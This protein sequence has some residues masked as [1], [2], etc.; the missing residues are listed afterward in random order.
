MNSK[1]KYWLSALLIIVIASA[2]FVQITKNKSWTLA[3]Y[4]SQKLNWNECYNNFE[5]AT[6]EVPVDYEKIDNQNFKLKVLRH[7]ASDNKNRIGALVVNPGG[8]GGSATDYAFNALSIVSPDIYQRYDIVGFDPRGV[9][10]SEPIRCLSNSEEDK[11]LDVSA[12]SGKPEE[13]TN[14]VEVSK[15]FAEK[16]AK[17]A[18][19]R[20]GHYSTLETAKDLE[21]LRQVLRE[22]KLN[23]LGKSYGTYLGT[24]YASLYPD[25][26]GKFVLDGAVAPNISLR[27]QEEAQ[28]LGFD[29][30]LSKYLIKNNKF[31]R[32][33][34]LK[35]IAGSAGKPLETNS[36]RKLSQSLI[37]TA[38]AQSLYNSKTGW[39]ELTIALDSAFSKSNPTNLFE[40][41]DEYNNRD[42]AG[43]FYSNQNDI[44]IM[45]TCLDWNE[46]R[47]LAEITNDQSEFKRISPVFGPYLNF[48]GLPCKYWKA[49]PQF[50]KISLEKI[51]TS[52]LLIIGVTGDPATPYKW[53]QSLTKSFL[54]AKLLTLKGEGH[55]G[56]NRGNK[57]IDSAVD[58]YFLTG[59]IPQTPLICAQSGN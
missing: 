35:F 6:L 30:A 50:P 31:T 39:P 19:G 46:N 24:L 29:S 44:S 20:L 59:K 9:N 33:D 43:N 54:N 3:K 15:G 52:P 55:T 53:A 11:F 2:S 28:A 45:T 42:S 13:I 10:G 26:V 40:L 32:G 1:K 8:P 36:G 41:A 27:D 34:I 56:H 48:A 7:K 37:V 4:Y 17:A 49:K 38:I 58:N 51:N 18:G 14:L 23:Y 21:V 5:C 22:A 25:K 12:T 47:S 57:C 16:C